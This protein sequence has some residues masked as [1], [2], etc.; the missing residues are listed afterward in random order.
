MVSLKEYV[1]ETNDFSNQGIIFKGINPIYRNPLILK[2]AMKC[3]E[4]L[5]F[6]TKPDLI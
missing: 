4:D 5:V 1:T 6:K 3:L 2:Q